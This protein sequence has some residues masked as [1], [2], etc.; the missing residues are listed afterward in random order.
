MW[1][2]CGVAGVVV[3]PLGPYR[4]FWLRPVERRLRARAGLEG[5]KVGRLV[6]RWGRLTSGRGIFLLASVP[7]GIKA[8]RLLTAREDVSERLA[9]LPQNRGL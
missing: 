6:K 8:Y 1:A 2:G 4:R 5:A 7:V 3:G 9:G